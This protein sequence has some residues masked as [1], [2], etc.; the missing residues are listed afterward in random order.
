[1]NNILKRVPPYPMPKLQRFLD[2]FKTIFKR[3]D[4]MRSAERYTTGLLSDIPY[5]NCGMIA[6]YVEGTTKQNLQEF[7]TNSSMLNV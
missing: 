1:M 2:N 7:L 3:S 4:T 5:K 6:E